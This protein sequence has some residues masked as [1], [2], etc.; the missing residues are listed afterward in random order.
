MKFIEQETAPSGK[1]RFLFAVGYEEI[2]ILSGL[3]SRYLEVLPR[4]SSHKLEFATV[5]TMRKGFGSFFNTHEKL[6]KK[7]HK[8][9]DYQCKYCKRMCRGEEALKKHNIDVHSRENSLLEQ[10]E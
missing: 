10:E 6:S 8:N 1:K 2:E 5:R 9:K 7:P 4:G 3:V